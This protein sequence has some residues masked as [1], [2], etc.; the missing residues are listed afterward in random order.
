M[1]TYTRLPNGTLYTGPLPQENMVGGTNEDIRNSQHNPERLKRIKQ[2][3]SNPKVLDYGCGNG[4]LVKYLRQNDIW[5]DGYDPFNNIYSSPLPDSAYDIVTL[6]EVIEHT[7]EPY[8]EV[9]DIFRILRPGGILMIETSFSDFLEEGDPYLNPAIGHSSI[10]SYKGLDELML[11]R[12]FEFG[13]KINRN[14]LLYRKPVKISLVTMGCGNVKVLKNTLDSF[15]DICDEVIYGDMLTFEQDREVVESYKKTYNLKSIRLPFDYI[16]HNGFG[17]LLNH[18]ASFAKNDIVIYMNTSEVVQTNNGML[19]IIQS[20]T[21]CNAFYFDHA[22]DP[23]KWG[24]C[25]NRKELSWSGMI[26]EQI[27]PNEKL[28]VCPNIIFTMADLEKDLDNPFKTL[29]FSDQKELNYFQMYLR[30]V[31]EPELLGYTHENWRNWAVEQYDSM[32]ERLQKKGKRYE[33]FLTGDFQMYLDDIMNNPDFEKE[34]FE[35]SDLINFQGNR[36]AIL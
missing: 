4:L 32:K 19:Q 2:L 16:F 24:R 7:A 14:T 23:H 26:H 35:S 25:Y 33:A 30:I 36:K 11:S 13:V 28:R 1:L 31:D 6:I 27:G 10:F 18:L 8:S 21:G 15:K 9:D 22:T 5:V 34:R 29:V 20:N 17:A 3:N 12:G